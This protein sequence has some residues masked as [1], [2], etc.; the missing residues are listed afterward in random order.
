MSTTVDIAPELLAELR[1]FRLAKRSSKGA[2]LVAKINKAQLRIEKED[3]FDPIT[4]E[5]LEEELPEHSPRFVV[6][7]MELRHEDG[8]ISYRT[9]TSWAPVSS[10]MELSTL[11]A[12][13]VSTFSVHADVGKV[14]DVREGGLTTA[15]LAERLGVRR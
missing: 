2:A 8:R 11:Y 1:T 7:S 3:V 5:D 6:L 13:A 4:P 9:D 14:I 15:M 12:S 10:S